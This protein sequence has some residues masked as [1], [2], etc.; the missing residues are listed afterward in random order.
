MLIF[1]RMGLRCGWKKGC[2][3]GWGVGGNFWFGSSKGFFEMLT[4]SLG[5]C[6]GF[7]NAWSYT[8][9]AAGSGSSTVQ[10]A[11]LTETYTFLFSGSWDIKTQQWGQEVSSV[12]Q[13][14]CIASQIFV[15]FSKVD[16][17]EAPMCLN[18][19]CYADTKRWPRRVRL[20]TC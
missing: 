3:G 14:A 20:P 18:C 11:R 1:V 17:W 9:G 5:Q 16:P 19:D 8:C 4:L 10:L 2:G 13:D 7:L 12:P 15:Q 6:N